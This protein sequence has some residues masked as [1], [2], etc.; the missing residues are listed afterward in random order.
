MQEIVYH[1]NYEIEEKYFWFL[2][3][4]KILLKIIDSLTDLKCGEQV[5]D[6]GCGTGGFAQLLDKKFDVT[7]LDMSPIALEYCQ[8]RGLSDLHNCLLSEFDKG[9]REIKAAFMLDV[10]EH[11]DDDKG[12][13]DD[14]YRLLDESGWFIATVPAYQWL[15]SHHD[16]VHEHK[17]RY[18]MK[19][20]KDLIGNA[21]FE[22]EYST[23]F[24]SFLFPTAVL[25]RAIDGLIG[26]KNQSPVDEVSPLLNTLF[27]KIF[28]S[29]SFFLPSVKFPFGLSILIVAKKV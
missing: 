18:T 16:V 1:S 27:T 20:F 15:W 6:I 21:G 17:R 23:Y 4:N 26:S 11:I 24:N 3:R 19:R 22:I 2:A 28:S 14:V 12:V 7:C 10:I 5:M 13:V 29:E 25:K 8:K 9:K